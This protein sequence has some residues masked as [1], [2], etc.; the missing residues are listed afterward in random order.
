[1]KVKVSVMSNSLRPHGLNSPW[2]FPGQNTG[3]GSHSLLQRIFQTQELNLGLMHCR[4]ILYQL[5]NQGSPQTVQVFIKL[6]LE[7]AQGTAK[8]DF[9]CVTGH[10]KLTIFFQWG[11]FPDILPEAVLVLHKGSMTFSSISN[12]TF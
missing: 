6:E 2:N 3:I 4:R 10:L 11:K 1:M 7:Y 8:K 5:S 12:Y 9:I